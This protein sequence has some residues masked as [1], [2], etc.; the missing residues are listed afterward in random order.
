MARAK[1]ANDKMD[2]GYVHYPRCYGWEGVPRDMRSKHHD[3][4]KA[5]HG[6]TPCGGT[7]IDKKLGSKAVGSTRVEVRV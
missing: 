5:L 7:G 3:E 4:R 1:G 6:V 2:G